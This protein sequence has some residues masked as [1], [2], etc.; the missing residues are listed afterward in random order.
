MA[1]ACVWSNIWSQTNKSRVASVYIWN[2]RK[3]L[4]AA[5]RKRT[6]Y[7]SAL[8]QGIEDGGK[9]C[10]WHVN[11][12]AQTDNTGHIWSPSCATVW[13]LTPSVTHSQEATSTLTMQTRVTFH[14]THISYL[15]AGV[16]LAVRFP[17]LLN[18]YNYKRKCFSDNHSLQYIIWHKNYTLNV[19]A[20]YSRIWTIQ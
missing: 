19:L 9:V 13:A 20:T 1:W 7:T 17:T 10:Y 2:Y 4:N 6:R 5:V 3:R 14:I 8:G 18:W 12:T 11:I 15:Y 16:S